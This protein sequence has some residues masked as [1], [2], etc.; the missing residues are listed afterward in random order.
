MYAIPS[1]IQLEIIAKKEEIIC[2]ILLSAFIYSFNL[3]GGNNFQLIAQKMHL[4]FFAR[5][6]V[7]WWISILWGA[8]S[9]ALC[10]VFYVICLISKIKHQSAKLVVVTNK[11]QAAKLSKSLQLKANLRD[12]HTMTTNTGLKL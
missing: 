1:N 4:G 2:Q 10:E 8:P 11:S 5:F 6:A 7:S 12:V 3:V 9:P